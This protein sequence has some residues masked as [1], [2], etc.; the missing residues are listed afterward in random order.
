LVK[1]KVVPLE[2]AWLLLTRSFLEGGQEVLQT[3]RVKVWGVGGVVRLVPSRRAEREV[4]STRLLD[5]EPDLLTKRFP[6]LAGADVPRVN[7]SWV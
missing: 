7:S 4:G 5:E 6:E 1:R 2:S 3:G